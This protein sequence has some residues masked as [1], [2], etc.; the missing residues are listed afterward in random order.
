MENYARSIIEDELGPKIAGLRPFPWEMVDFYALLYTIRFMGTIG[1]R[2]NRNP[3]SQT[4][5][6][7]APL[8]E[9]IAHTLM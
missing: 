8:L 9:K 4:N 3:S 7:I 5:P 6:S 2:L 1:Q